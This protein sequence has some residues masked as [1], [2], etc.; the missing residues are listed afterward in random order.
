M[1]DF[2]VFSVLLG[3]LILLIYYAYSFARFLLTENN[4]DWTGESSKSVLATGLIVPYENKVSETAPVLREID[5]EYAKDTKS[6]KIYYISDIH[7]NHK[8]FKK[9]PKKVTNQKAMNFIRAFVEIMVASA[10]NSSSG[11]FLLIAGDVS[12]NFEIS[13]IFYRELAKHWEPKQIVVVLGNHELWDV[14]LNNSSESQP[15]DLEEIF[16]RYRDLFKE[17]KI[18][19]LQNELLLAADYQPIKIIPEEELRN[20]STEML[21]ELCSKKPVVILGGL[22]FSGLEAN[23]NAKQGLYRNTIGSLE[24]DIKQTKRFELIYNNVGKAIGDSQVIVLTHTPKENWSSEAYNSNWIYVN[25]HTHRN[26]YHYNESRTV[27]ADNQIGYY[28]MKV[29]LKQFKISKYYDIYKYYPDGIYNIPVDNYWEFNRGLGLKITMNRSDGEIHMLKK[30]NIYCFLYKKEDSGGL[31]LLNG[32]A[33]RKLSNKNIDYYFERIP[34]Y[35]EATKRIFKSYHQLLKSTSDYVKR[36]GGEGTIHGCIVNIDYFNHIYVSPKDGTMTPYYALSI[37]NKYTYPNLKELILENRFDLYDSYMRELK[38]G[39]G[40]FL[41]ME[42]ELNLD[43]LKIPHFNSDTSM[44]RVSNMF[45]T[46]QYLTD[47]NVIRYWN[48]RILETN[49]P[50]DSKIDGVALNAGNSMSLS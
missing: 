35:S 22:G 37:K 36:F 46:I 25:G 43:Q 24:E 8:L 7:V 21:R 12:Y 47:N 27:Y 44:Y 32:G 4:P 2:F 50:I 38:S 16:Q 42:G 19:F 45:R 39:S 29:G 20:I 31:Y 41:E 34:D 49:S 6:H 17:L 26:E 15:K 28:T 18:N 40:N 3:C 48:D 30:Q 1:L 5:G 23:F 33:L 14:D 13:E 11:D 10:S 9:Y